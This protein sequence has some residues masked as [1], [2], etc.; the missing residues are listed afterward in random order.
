MG[1]RGLRVTRDIALLLRSLIKKNSSAAF[2]YFVHCAEP[3]TIFALQS[4]EELNTSTEARK[5]R[6]NGQVFSWSG[7]RYADIIFEDDHE[8]NVDEMSELLNDKMLTVGYSPYFLL[9]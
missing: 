2:L 6:P 1:S 3:S 7:L 4:V 8:V 9:L 5:T